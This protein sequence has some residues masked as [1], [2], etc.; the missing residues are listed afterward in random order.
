[1]RELQAVFKHSKSA[2]FK[3]WKLISFFSIPL[4]LSLLI[5]LFSPMPT[6]QAFGAT[7]L[8]TGSIPEMTYFE[9]GVVII[10]FLASM[11][12]VSFALVAINLVI[13]SQ[14]TLTNIKSEVVDG[15]EKYSLKLFAL[16]VFAWVL[17]LAV[18]LLSYEYGLEKVIGPL[19]AF[20]VYTAL[21]YVSPA[22][23]IDEIGGVR[24]IKA[25]V[26]ML[27]KKPKFFAA[28]FALAFLALAIPTQAFLLVMP[29]NIAEYLVLALNSLFL[30]PFLVVLQ[31][32]MYL[33]KYTILDK[34]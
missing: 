20:V 22:I 31:T 14:R 30:L 8:R 1:M 33:T 27:F 10:S 32:Q 28:W 7:F 4:L 18:S 9:W 29:H 3:N 11:F 26:D 24:A 21:F 34:S 17:S 16:Y 13:K 25:S 6:F 19:F 15:I 12:L 23:V 2:Y 5:P